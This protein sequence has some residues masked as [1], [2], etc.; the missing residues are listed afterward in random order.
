MTKLSKITHIIYDM[1]GLL[2]D[3]EPFYTQ[4]TQTIVGEYGKVF[5]WSIKSQM[6]GKKSSDSARILV[7]ALDLPITP[8]EYL[9][10]RESMLAELFPNAQPMPG[11]VRLTQHLKNHNIPQAVATSSDHNMFQLKT[12]L[13]GQWFSLFD[14]IVTASDPE[15]KNGKPAPDIFLTAAR[16]M[17][18]VPSQ[19]LVF[20]DAPSG[21]NAALSAGMSVVMVPDANMDRSVFNAAHQI[22][23]SLN[24]FHPEEWGLPTFNKDNF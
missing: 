12:S 14:C 2:L 6:I 9:E 20:E 7:N 21:M 13:H 4:V 11:A 1:D 18:G 19:C 17:G 15:V 5:D 24:E 23:D 16:R 22:L 3:T 10:A 8:Q